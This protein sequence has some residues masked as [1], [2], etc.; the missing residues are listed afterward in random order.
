MDFQNISDEQ[1]EKIKEILTIIL[2]PAPMS[3]DFIKAWA[4][5]KDAAPEALKQRLIMAELNV[6]YLTRFVAHSTAL[7]HSKITT[8]DDE[9]RRMSINLRKISKTAENTEKNFKELNRNL[10][11]LPQLLGKPAGHA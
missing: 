7:M 10:R 8:C 6:E 5:S 2:N 9:I 3:K 4:D 1:A 11:Q